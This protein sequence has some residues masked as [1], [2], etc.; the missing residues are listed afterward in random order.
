MPRLARTSLLALALLLPACSDSSGPEELL[1]IFE[2]DKGVRYSVGQNATGAITT[3]DCTIP[4][5]ET[6]A[7]FY[8]FRLSSNGPVSIVVERSAGSGG[9]IVA[10]VGPAEELLDFAEVS[11]GQEA[12]VGG[13]LDAGTYVIVIGAQVPGQSGYSMSSSATLPPS[14][15]AF[16]NC[17]VAQLY[18]F[19]TTVSGTLGTGDCL[20]PDGSWMDRHQFSLTSQQA[21]TIDLMSGDFDAYLYLFNSEGTVMAENDDFGSGLDSRI[22]LTLPAGTYSI[23][24]TSYSPGSAGAYT[25]RIQ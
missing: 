22:S 1:T 14:G 19:G 15:P 13:Q 12:A 20:T 24:A 10:L 16:F 4:E 25:L 17:T 18:T 21:V 3:S 9:M 11:P 6:R 8:E 7:D 5:S 23:G 2:C